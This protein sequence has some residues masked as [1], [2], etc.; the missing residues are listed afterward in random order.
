M[1]ESGAGDPP[2]GGKCCGVRVWVS[3]RGSSSGG[4]EGKGR[5]EM[6][7]TRERREQKTF[8]ITTV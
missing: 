2:Y 5:K 4:R 3:G 1:E 6:Y 7:I 8:G